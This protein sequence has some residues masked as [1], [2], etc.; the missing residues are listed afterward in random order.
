MTNDAGR[1]PLTDDQLAD[2]LRFVAR[3]CL[4]VERGL[5]PLAHLRSLMDPA[6]RRADTGQLGR[7]PRGG[8][9]QDGQ[10]GHPQFSRLSDT[11]IVATVVTRTEGNR[12][13]ALTLRLRAKDGRWRVADLHRLLAATHYVTAA[14]T[15]Q[16]RVSS[17]EGL[18]AHLN[19]E[20]R[21]ADA[22]RRAA[23]RRLNDL[24]H[25]APGHRAARDVVAYWNR[26]VANLDRE[27]AELTTRH[28]T[29]GL[30]E[31]MLRR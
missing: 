24:S 12:W 14:R 13:G 11:H 21:I 20:R 16:E 22:A 17:P 2:I 23:T 3:I 19:E 7:F 25:D 10:I 9:V 30:A 5:R 18:P 26:K 4:E 29:R 6:L 15:A 1:T 31:R 27:L 8:P 28:Q